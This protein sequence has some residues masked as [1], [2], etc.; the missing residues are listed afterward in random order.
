MTPVA[1]RA[2]TIA[3]IAKPIPTASFT[4]VCC[5]ACPA[6]SGS[7]VISVPRLPSVDLAVRCKPEQ[8]E[9][10][11]NAGSPKAPVKSV[12]FAEETG[13]YIAEK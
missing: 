11:S 3:R 1:A 8:A 2:T 9:Q 7:R 5:F 10:H 13:N 4:V 6:G 12:F